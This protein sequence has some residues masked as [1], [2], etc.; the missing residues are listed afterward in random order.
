MAY[1]DRWTG[2]VPVRTPF[3]PQSTVRD[4]VHKSESAHHC[5]AA[6]FAIDL[7]RGIHFRNLMGTPGLCRAAKCSTKQ[8][9]INLAQGSWIE[10]GANLAS[11]IVLLLVS[12]DAWLSRDD[13]HAPGQSLTIHSVFST[14]DPSTAFNVQRPTSNARARRSIDSHAPGVETSKRRGAREHGGV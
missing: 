6:M 9:I 10:K 3:G 4:L 1:M 7:E 11:A 12:M 5:P 13:A 8:S 14:V 2:Y